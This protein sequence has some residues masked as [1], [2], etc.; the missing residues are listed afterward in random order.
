M[1]RSQSLSLLLLATVGASAFALAKRD[2]SQKEEDALVYR[3]EQQCVAA[4]V[5]TAEECR[6]AYQSALAAARTKAP[7][8]VNRSDCEKHHGRDHCEL[9]SGFSSGYASSHYVPRLSAFMM[10]RNAAQNMPVQPLYRHE[11]EQGQQSHSGGHGSYCSSGGGR[12][13]TSTAAAT[14]ARVASATARESVATARIIP[15][16]GSGVQVSR[17]GFGSTGH[18]MMRS[19]SSSG[20]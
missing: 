5:R 3:S 2:P 18:S 12:V 4:K 1:K 17:S 19:F 14:T 6:S 7:R 16:G 15:A 10:G 9:S 20:S 8:Y 13:Y 11:E